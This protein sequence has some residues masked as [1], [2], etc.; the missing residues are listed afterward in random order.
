[1]KPHKSLIFITCFCLALFSHMTLASNSVVSKPTNHDASSS[2]IKHSKPHWAYSGSEGPSRWGSLAREYSTCS[3]GRNQSPININGTTADKLFRL[4]FNYQSVPM[5]ILNNGHTIQV[6]YNTIDNS[7]ENKI[8]IGGKSYLMASAVQHNSSISISG[9][10]YKLLQIHFHSPSEHRVNGGSYPLEAHFVHINAQNQ[11]AVIGVIFKMGSSNS[12]LN[13]L[14]NQMPTH[15][16]PATTYNNIL[17]NGNEL[18]PANKSYYHYRG[19]L[20][21]PPC[22]EGV[23]WF[24]M[25]N[26]ANVSQ[27]QVHKF[28]S[29][30]GNNNR[31]IQPR[32]QRFLL[33][34]Q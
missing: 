4:A 30:V 15:A 32:N 24:V 2:P 6:N 31:P 9:E 14:W 34:N 33:R 21:T 27:S 22:S 19:S 20:T 10:V 17:I 3:A 26:Y 16:G 28:N 1:M 13:K 5:S 25:Q 23:R 29:I 18:L 11:L 8:E 12:F 7:E